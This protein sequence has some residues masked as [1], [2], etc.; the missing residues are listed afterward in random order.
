[1]IQVETSKH[2]LAPGIVL[3][4]TSKEQAEAIRLSI[5]GTITCNGLWRSSMVIN[6]ET[7]KKE[8]SLRR[9]CED[10]RL[11]DPEVYDDESLKNLS[12]DVHSWINDKIKD[13]S[14]QHSVEETVKGPYILIKY[15]DSD[16]F[17]YHVD[18][19]RTYPRT[20][21]MSAYLNDD[22]EGGEIEFPLFGI[23]HKPEAGD[24]IVFSSSFPYMHR[25]NP[26][27]SGTR[28]AIVNWYRYA[29]YPE[30]MKFGKA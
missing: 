13:Y 16:K 14:L 30:E 26:V 5:E 1:L 8:L 7:Y 12:L 17:D 19:G 6:P 9:K 2:F 22:Y 21:S 15:Q 25:V 4:K 28:Y 24:I 23:S 3:Y 11:D 10:Y 27:I 18:D 20:I 29:G